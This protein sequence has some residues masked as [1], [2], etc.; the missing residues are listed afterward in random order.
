[1][2]VP[3]FNFVTLAVIE[4]SVTKFYLMND[5]HKEWQK[6]KANLV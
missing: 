1:M 6:D 2:Y 4:K 5:G 3:N